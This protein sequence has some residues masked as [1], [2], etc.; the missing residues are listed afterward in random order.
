MKCLQERPR[1]IPRRVVRT[2]VDHVEW[3]SIPGAGLLSDSQ[4]TGAIMTPPN[5]RRGDGDSCE[6]IRW[7]P[8]HAEF[9]QQPAG[10]LRA[11]PTSAFE[12]VGEKRLPTR[13]QLVA[14]AIEIDRALAHE[15]GVRALGRAR[16]E[17]KHRERKFR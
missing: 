10:D 3:P 8:R 13:A 5:Q 12:A 1:L 17:G 2:L 15:A 7:D 9:T 4:P 6:L 14:Q 16:G 11:G